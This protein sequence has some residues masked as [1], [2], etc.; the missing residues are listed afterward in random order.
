MRYIIALLF[1]VFFTA[2][3]AR[4]L[5]VVDSVKNNLYGFKDIKSLAVTSVKDQASSG[6]CWCYSGISFIESE[7]LLA[8]KDTVGLSEMWIVRNAYYEKAIKYVRMHGAINFDEGGGSTD[9]FDMI[10]KY[11]IVPRDVYPGLNYGTNTNKHAELSA[12]LKAYLQ[13]VVSNPNKTLSDAWV[14]GL[15]GI[16][17]AYFGEVPK[18]FTYN[19][20]NFTPKEFAN[21]LGISLDDYVCLGSFMHYPYYT[22]FTLEIPDNWAW[23]KTYNIPFDQLI[24]CI[25]TAVKSGYSVLWGSDVSETGF[26]YKKGYAII[27]EKELIKP[28]GTD[29]EKWNNMSK[30]DKE[31]A[32]VDGPNNKEKIIT[33][34]MRQKSFDNYETTD[35]H[36]MLIMGLAQDINKTPY[37]KIKNSWGTTQIF[38]GYF[39]A[40]YPYVLYKTI[41][42]MV[43]VKAL[44]KGIRE[45]LNNK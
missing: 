25:E 7:L 22:W 23:S 29:E 21:Q 8:G 27:P 28:T 37:F 16:L 26:K 4:T 1:G 34:E 18:N 3:N 32:R 42:I 10:K 40:S 36:G 17:D 2:A 38:K 19:G 41:N 39:Y 44:P 15:N 9:V 5:N 33:A 30:D 31:K 11:G 20:N 6:T 12:I 35:D 13:T 24:P 14:R 43:N 45:K